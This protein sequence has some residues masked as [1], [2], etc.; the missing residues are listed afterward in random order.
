[1]SGLI[2]MAELVDAMARHAQLV[3]GDALELRSYEEGALQ[4]T[5]AAALEAGVDPDALITVSRA[6]G[7]LQA[8][9]VPS[10]EQ[11]AAGFLG[12]F[13]CCAMALGRVTS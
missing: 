12:G 3:H 8:G 5:R 9:E 4:A 2:G 13:L 10:Q 11:G 6:Y 7:E 1:V